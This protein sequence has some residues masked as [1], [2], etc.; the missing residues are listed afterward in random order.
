MKS[1]FSANLVTVSAKIEERLERLKSA[2]REEKKE[3]NRGC[4]HPDSKE[5]KRTRA[6]LGLNSQEDTHTGGDIVAYRCPNCGM[7]FEELTLHK[8]SAQHNAEREEG[9]KD[10]R[11]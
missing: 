3:Q 11:M 7:E 1:K 8:E 2:E 10:D 9:E 6:F 5:V 4:K